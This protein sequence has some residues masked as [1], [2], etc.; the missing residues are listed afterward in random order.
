MRTD[1]TDRISATL[2]AA[3]FLLA[4]GALSFVGATWSSNV[5]YSDEWGALVPR[6]SHPTRGLATWLSTLHNGHWIPLPRALALLVLESAR[7]HWLALEIAN[8]GMLLVGAVLVTRSC[9]TRGW[10]RVEAALFSTLLLLGPSSLYHVLFS[11]Q[12]PFLV[13]TCLTPFLLA[14]L[15]RP[16]RSP[17]L[18]SHPPRASARAPPCAAHRHRP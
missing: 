18:T 17:H 13:G 3:L 11:F 7:W 16:R 5:P 15:T 2:T 9:A 12:V 8:V 14:G 1:R 6:A 4:G 10:S